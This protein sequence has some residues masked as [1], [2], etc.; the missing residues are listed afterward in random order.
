MA[1]P[2]VPD[3]RLLLYAQASPAQLSQAIITAREALG[4]YYPSLDWPHWHQAF[5]ELEPSLKLEAGQI[6][7]TLEG[8]NELARHLEAMILPVDVM[9]TSS[10]PRA[11]W[12]PQSGEAPH[13][14]V[15]KTY[16]IKVEVLESLNRVSFWR[17][18]RKVAL[19]NLALTQ[20]L[21]QYPES[22]IPIP[23]TTSQA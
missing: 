16:S 12:A 19:V 5:R 13:Q 3:P 7:M 23:N 14:E 8:L 21:S 1:W 20:F 9:P 22:Q 10:I 15:K 4:P 18:E 11:T 2:A 17:R 6:T